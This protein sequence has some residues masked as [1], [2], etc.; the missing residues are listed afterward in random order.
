MIACRWDAA[1]YH[2][3]IEIETASERETERVR[4]RELICGINFNLSCAVHFTFVQCCISL[5]QFWPRWETLVSEFMLI[6]MTYFFMNWTAENDVN[7]LI[8]TNIKENNAKHE[9]MIVSAAV[10]VAV[11]LQI[12]N[13]K[14]HT[15]S[16]KQ[17]SYLLYTSL[18]DFIFLNSKFIL[19][20][21][22]ILL[23]L[24]N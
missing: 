15:L 9:F 21:V 23:M 5:N 19:Y 12:N 13:V 24:L 18:N 1:Q 20:C 3:C 14:S 10:K 11:I 6:W 17:S 4:E 22:N 7:Q 8:N 16:P 2:N